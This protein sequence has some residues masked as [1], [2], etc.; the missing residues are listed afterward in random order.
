M[1]QWL[2]SNCRFMVARITTLPIL[3]YLY[4]GTH[5]QHWSKQKRLRW[6]LFKVDYHSNRNSC[7]MPKVIFVIP[8]MPSSI[9][10]ILTKRILEW[11]RL[12]K[13]ERGD[14]TK[15]ILNHFSQIHWSKRIGINVFQNLNKIKNV[16]KFRIRICCFSSKGPLSFAENFVTWIDIP[17]IRWRLER[18]KIRAKIWKFAP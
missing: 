7:N 11:S 3:P 2:D 16:F 17:V 9:F 13:A 1:I 6:K 18:L 14:N 10:G 8:K 5:L 15:K 12:Q 4:T